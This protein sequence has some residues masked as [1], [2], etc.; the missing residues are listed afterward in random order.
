MLSQDR[1]R[2]LQGKIDGEGLGCALLFY[3]RDIYYYTGT[4]QPS[5]LLVLPDQYFLFVRS[6]YDFAIKDVFIS[7]EHIYEERRLETIY[8]KICS[9]L[10]NRKIATELDILPTKQ[11]FGYKK[12]FEGW[13]FSDISPMVLEQRMTKDPYE[14]EQIRKACMAIDAGH[15]AVLSTLRE[16]VTELELAAAVENAHRLAGHEGVFF[17][18]LPDFFMSRGPIGSG[19]NLRKFSG[20]V[21]SV[22]GAGLSPS[23]PVGPSMRRIEVG[24]MAVVDIPTFVNG[25]HADQTRTYF[26][27]RCGSR[28]RDRYETLKEIHESVIEGIRPGMSGDDIYRTAME[29][30]EKLKVAAEFLSFGNGKRSHMIGH[31]LGLEINEPPIISAGSSAKILENY[32]LG[33][34]MHLLDEEA[35]AMKLEDTVLVGRHGNE[36]LTVSARELGEVF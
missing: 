6:G 19:P 5:F 9:G 3:S 15:R 16:G 10:K 7:T 29:K 17:M 35:G 32:I 14:I 1:I 13:E 30:A 34:E 31:G 28:L 27:G 22:T 11:Y 36:I 18:R 25:Y 26:L 8:A 12:I 24:D 2:Q 20:V 21:Y 33:I 4:A 23:V